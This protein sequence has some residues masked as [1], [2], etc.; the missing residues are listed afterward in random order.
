MP[1]R[2]NWFSVHPDLLACD[3]RPGSQLVRYLAVDFDTSLNDDRF[4]FAPAPESRS[5]QNF[6]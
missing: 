2:R 3:I 4:T 6:L 1:D 5:R